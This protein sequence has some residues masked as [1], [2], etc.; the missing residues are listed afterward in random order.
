M[1]MRH[2]EGFLCDVRTRSVYE[3]I[4]MSVVSRLLSPKFYTGSWINTP[5]IIASH[6][7]QET[8][9]HTNTIS[10]QRYKRYY[11]TPEVNVISTRL[12][13]YRNSN[14][15]LKGMWVLVIAG[16]IIC[17]TFLLNQ[18]LYY[19]ELRQLFFG[20]GGVCRAS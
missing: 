12:Y 15:I 11:N 18:K 16:V 8:K 19:R 6:L 9:F 20:G 14:K 17:F 5:S 1:F 7:Q 4:R 10:I 2:T 3:Y 13:I